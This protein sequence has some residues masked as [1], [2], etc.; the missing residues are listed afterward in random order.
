MTVQIVL[1]VLSQDSH[2]IKSSL[3]DKRKN[4]EISRFFTSRKYYQCAKIEVL[5]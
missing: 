1:R 3:L 4:S 2:Q 5:H